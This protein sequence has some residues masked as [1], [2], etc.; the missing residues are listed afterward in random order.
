MVISRVAFH[1]QLLVHILCGL[2]KF[3]IFTVNA[4]IVRTPTGDD[5][6][7]LVHTELRMMR[8][9]RVSVALLMESLQK[10]QEKDHMK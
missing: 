4:N 5:K 6:R 3:F 1:G 7:D 10:N 9:N 8:R 2:L